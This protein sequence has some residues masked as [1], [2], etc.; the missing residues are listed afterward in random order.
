MAGNDSRPLPPFDA[1]I[2]GGGPAGLS[3]ALVLGRCRR[4]V[5]VCDDGHQRNAASKELHGFLTRDGIPPLELLSIAR[6]QLNIY[7]TVETRHAHVSNAVH[8]GNH[9]EVTLE[10]GTRIPCRKLLLATGVSDNIPQLAGLPELY[11]RSVFHCPYCDGW[12][13]RDQAVAIYGPP[14]AACGLA[15]EMTAWTA[16]LVVCTDGRPVDPQSVDRLARYG[17]AIREECVER[18]H[19]T[20]GQLERVTFASGPPHDCRALFLAT[21][22][23]QRS[24]LAARLGCTF[25]EKGA[26]ATGEYETT[27]IPGLYVAGDASR[28]VHLAIV[29]AAEG[30]QAAFAI[31]TALLKEDLATGYDVAT[32]G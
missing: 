16:N 18:L 20:A 25:N 28:L 11:G 17:I 13:V 1:V 23:R 12:E 29:A 14:D 3:A 2:V 27:N 15:L 5:L 31:N 10:D 22:S 6:N 9:F 30:A 7:S 26:V 24:N 4:R 32:P 8:A 19:G 21:G